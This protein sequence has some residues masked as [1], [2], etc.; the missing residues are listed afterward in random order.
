MV[1]LQ[2]L[3]NLFVPHEDESVQL[4]IERLRSVVKITVTAVG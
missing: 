4:N 2:P 1:A 3:Q